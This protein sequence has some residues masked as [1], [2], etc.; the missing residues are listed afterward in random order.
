MAHDVAPLT[1]EG[2][3]LADA[4]DLIPEKLHPDGELIVISQVNVH[5]VATDPE[6]V[7]DEIHIVALILQLD[8]TAAELVPF[9]LHA[10]AQADDHAAVVDG[11][12]QRVDA[13]HTGHDDDIALF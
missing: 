9:H 6:L 13:G 5:N 3:K 10:G 4:V 12:A 2:V 1:G 8:Q 11:V 7:A